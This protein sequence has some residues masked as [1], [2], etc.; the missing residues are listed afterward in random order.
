MLGSNGRIVRA[1]K[2]S[3]INQHV[4]HAGHLEQFLLFQIDCVL[5][6]NRPIKLEFLLRI[7]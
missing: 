4:D 5:C 1:L 2:R 3:E 7:Y 6:P